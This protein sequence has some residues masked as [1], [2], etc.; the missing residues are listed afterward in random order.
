MSIQAAVNW[1]LV[2]CVTILSVKTP[3]ACLTE[4]PGLS[5][6]GA[7][8]RVEIKRKMCPV[9]SR[10]MQYRRLTSFDTH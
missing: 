2:S 7:E 10:I 8:C 3:N 9:V 1:K 5:E 4:L 6:H